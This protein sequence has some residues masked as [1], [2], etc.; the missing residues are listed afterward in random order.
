MNLFN[1]NTV[2]IF[3]NMC[4]YTRMC[5]YR[6]IMTTWTKLQKNS[7]QSDTPS[8]NPNP[9]LSSEIAQ[10]ESDF[11]QRVTRMGSLL[12]KNDLIKL[13]IKIFHALVMTH[14]L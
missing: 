5:I 9:D 10:S 6:G 4:N 11:R 1:K 13:E 3:H 7:A 8:G 14:D 2:E 12:A